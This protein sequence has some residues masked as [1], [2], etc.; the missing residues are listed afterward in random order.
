MTVETQFSEKVKMQIK[1]TVHNLVLAFGGRS[2]VW[3]PAIGSALAGQTNACGLLY[4]H[5][6]VR[7]CRR[8]P[9]NRLGDFRVIE[10]QVVREIATIAINFLWEDL[11]FLEEETAI[12]DIVKGFVDSDFFII[13]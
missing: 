3:F 10:K 8:K 9:E 11:T 4:G 6:S 5:E 13:E 12:N 2:Q 7:Q 1:T